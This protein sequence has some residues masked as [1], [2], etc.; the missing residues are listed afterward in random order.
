MKSMSDGL[1]LEMIHR[2]DFRSGIS[3]V[4]DGVLGGSAPCGCD[5]GGGGGRMRHTRGPERRMVIGS[6][7]GAHFS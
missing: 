3:P 6:R 2:S 7:H 1:N 4:A 5:G